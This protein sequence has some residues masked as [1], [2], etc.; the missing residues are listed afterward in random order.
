MTTGNPAF[1]LFL[2][3]TGVQFR[4]E[5]LYVGDVSEQKIKYWPIRTWEVVGVRLYDGLYVKD[6]F[7][8]SQH[9][10]NTNV[11]LLWQSFTL[12]SCFVLSLFRSSLPDVFC[13]KGILRN[14]TNFTGK[15]LYQSLFF[16]K[17]AGLL[18]IY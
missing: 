10:F 6:G 9:V 18:Q 17:F 2:Y 8:F 3:L 1:C 15:H 12:K 11:L 13:N 7:S 14:F 5:L 4:S 16:N